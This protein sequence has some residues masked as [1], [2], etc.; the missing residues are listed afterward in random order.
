MTSREAVL[1]RVSLRLSISPEEA[2]AGAALTLTATAECPD[3]FDLSDDPVLFLDGAGHELG[4]APL[5]A[6]EENDFRAGITITAPIELGEYGYSAV[7]VPAEGDDVAHAGARAEARCSVKAHDVYVNVWDIP[8]AITAGDAFS[9]HVGLKCSCGCDLANRGFVVRDQAGTVVASGKLGDAVWPGTSA[10]RYAEVQA[11]APPD[12]GAHHWTVE[13]A[14]SNKGIAHSPGSLAMH[15]GTVAAPDREIRIEAVDRE[16]GAPLK[17]IN[18]IIGPY[19]AT[20]GG[21]GVAQ[22]RVVSDHYVLHASGLQRMPYRDHLDA[23][24]TIGLRLLMA[25]ELPQEHFL[26]PVHQEPSIAQV[27]K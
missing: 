22:V 5:A 26:P 15:V 9:F 4:S 8:S 2:D 20:T 10:L 25:V 19:R 21:D 27:L 17:G 24:R 3:D 16:S 11:V 6:L 12:L 23:T 7:L 1:F 18:L 13:F 14:G